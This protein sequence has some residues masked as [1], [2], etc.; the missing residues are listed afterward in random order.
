MTNDKS[1]KIKDI[2]TRS[3]NGNKTAN[4]NNK[5]ERKKFECCL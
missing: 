5:R 4:S 3:L 2:V 1:R